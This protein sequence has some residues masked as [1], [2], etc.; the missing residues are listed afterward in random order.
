MAGEDV[1][2]R[3]LR[4]TLSCAA[5]EGSATEVACGE[6]AAGAALQVRLES[7]RGWFG[8]ELQHDHQGPWAVFEGVPAGSVVVP[9]QPI[10][11][12]ARQGDVV[13]SRVDVAP[14]SPSSKAGDRAQDAGVESLRVVRLRSGPA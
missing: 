5:N 1:R 14:A 6:R 2:R 9:L 8:R 3:L 4:V 13:T 12:I 7:N 10:V 11:D